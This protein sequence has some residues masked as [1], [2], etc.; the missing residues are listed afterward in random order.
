MRISDWSSD[1][2]SSDL[3]PCQQCISLRFVDSQPGDF[4]S[5]HVV[6]SNRRRATEHLQEPNRIQHTSPWLRVGN[7]L[8]TACT[9]RRSNGKASHAFHRSVASSS[10]AVSPRSEARRVGEEWARPGKA[11]WAPKKKK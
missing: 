7:Q 1:V 6:T 4:V 2:C 3:I 8:R 10:P 11:R 5:P 9:K